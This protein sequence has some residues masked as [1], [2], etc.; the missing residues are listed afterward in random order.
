MMH[1]AQEPNMRPLPNGQWPAALVIAAARG[2]ID[3][4]FVGRLRMQRLSHAAGMG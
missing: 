2:W 3:L 4:G 1:A